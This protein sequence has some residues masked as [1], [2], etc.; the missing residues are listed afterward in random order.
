MAEKLQ[1][2]KYFKFGIVYE[3]LIKFEKALHSWA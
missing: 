2:L 1:V 3:I